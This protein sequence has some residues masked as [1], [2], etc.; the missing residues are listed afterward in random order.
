VTTAWVGSDDSL[1]LGPQETGA[2]TALPMWIDYMRVA[3]RDMPMTEPDLPAG[4]VTVRTYAGGRTAFETF[5]A[6]DA[7]RASSQQGTHYQ[8]TETKP[9]AVDQLF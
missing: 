9:S 5:R 8:A 6:Q 4:L 3:L 7:P 2:R 1:T